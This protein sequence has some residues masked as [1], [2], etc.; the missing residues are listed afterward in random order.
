MYVCI[1]GRWLQ[2]MLVSVVVL[3]GVIAIQLS[4]W[5]GPHLPRAQAQI[6]DSGLQRKQLLE[7]Q[8][9]ISATLDQILQHL[10]T[11]TIKVKVI[12]T[13]KDIKSTSKPKVKDVKK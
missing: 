8:A 10:R 6:P 9:E 5:L 12:G 1:N 3:L 13:D 2:W 11:Q 4:V 7:S